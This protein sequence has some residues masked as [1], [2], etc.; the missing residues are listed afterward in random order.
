MNAQNFVNPSGSDIY[1]RTDQFPN[2][3]VVNPDPLID[4]VPVNA[5]LLPE[6]PMEE[7]VGPIDLVNEPLTDAAPLDETPVEVDRVA[8][9]IVHET[10]METNGHP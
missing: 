10:P 8:E 1:D 6:V 9:T 7:T 4:A 5:D 2:I 3:P